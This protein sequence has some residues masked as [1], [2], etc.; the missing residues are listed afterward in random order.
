MAALGL[1]AS[2]CVAS[3][4]GQEG[5]KGLGAWVDMYDWSPSVVGSSPSFGLAQVDALATN[6]VQTLY[7]Q[8]GRDRATVDILDETLLKKLIARAK[9]KGMRVVGWYLPTFVDVNKDVRRINAMDRLG[10]DGVGIDIEATNV[11]DP[12]VRT[13]RLKS[14]TKS[15]R[16]HFGAQMPL[17]AIT[18]P[19]IHLTAVNPSIWPNFP[20]QFIG[21]SYDALIPMSYWT[22]RAKTSPYRNA[23][24]HVSED[25]RLA[26]QL[27]G[28]PNMAVHVVGGLALSGTAAEVRDMV[29]ACNAGGCI[30]GSYYDAGT[31]RADMWPEL[32][33]LR[34]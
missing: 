15:V 20:W 19:P 32:R 31:T 8:T 14:V 23:K 18:Y 1:V 5:F 28:K 29:A 10:V 9:S 16:S 30:G 24:Y 33:K 11:A 27:T 7:I 34:S 17:G 12:A 2:A 25:I 3:P 4:V 22:L 6:G 13:A 26:K 21:D